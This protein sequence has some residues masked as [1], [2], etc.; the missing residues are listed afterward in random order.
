VRCL[1][2]GSCGETL[3]VMRTQGA[4]NSG[5]AGK[6]LNL[7]TDVC[8]G[9][10]LLMLLQSIKAAACRLAVSRLA[11]AIK[12]MIILV[13]AE[14]WWSIIKT[15]E[16]GIRMQRGG[17]SH[18]SRYDENHDAEAPVECRR[19]DHDGKETPHDA[20]PQCSRHH[21]SRESCCRPQGTQGLTDPVAGVRQR[22]AYKDEVCT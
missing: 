3:S 1:Q 22:H 14:D 16:A 10:T 18:E 17:G 19:E 12:R 20:E 2:A 11:A 5:G 8:Q 6:A 7:R 15:S 4:E 21:P 9:L 13:S